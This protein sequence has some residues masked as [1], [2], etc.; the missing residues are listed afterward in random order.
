MKAH[1]SITQYLNELDQVVHRTTEASRR[2]TQVVRPACNIPRQ[3]SIRDDPF[4]CTRDLLGEDGVSS[5]TE[6][7][8]GIDLKCQVLIV[9]AHSCVATKRPAQ[10]GAT[11]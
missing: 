8:Q 2:Q 10:T 7:S 5:D 1:A 6:T 3:A 4:F 11:M 9:R